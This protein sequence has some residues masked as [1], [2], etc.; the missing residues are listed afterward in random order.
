[1][2]LIINSETKFWFKNILTKQGGYDKL[3]IVK[4]KYKKPYHERWREW[5]Q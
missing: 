3:C 1:M 5:A 2:N 4:N